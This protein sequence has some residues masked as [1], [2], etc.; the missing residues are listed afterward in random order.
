MIQVF[1]THR[2]LYKNAVLKAY[3]LANPT[4]QIHFYGYDDGDLGLE[5]QTNENGYICG[6]SGM[7]IL[8]SLGVDE[9][10]IIKVSL[11]GGTSWPI[12]WVLDNET[13]N[14]L[15]PRDIGTLGYYDADGVRQTWDPT[16]G[17]AELPN[18]GQDGSTTWDEKNMTIDGS[19]CQYAI[20]IWT[21]NIVI[22]TTYENNAVMLNCNSSRAGQQFVIY[23]KQA[24]KNRVVLGFVNGPQPI[25][26]PADM[27]AIVGIYSYTIDDEE[28]FYAEFVIVNTSTLTEAVVKSLIADE[29]GPS[30]TQTN[31]YSGTIAE[32]DQVIN[33]TNEPDTGIYFVTLEATV[34]GLKDVTINVPN[35][36]HLGTCQIV[37]DMDYADYHS[38]ANNSIKIAIGTDTP[39]EV[40]K[41]EDTNRYQIV[42]T[43]VTWN[44]GTIPYH[45]KIINV[46]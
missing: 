6:G 4:T 14:M 35:P 31:G 32:N 34:A 46:A 43:L 36:A 38:A 3:S 39:L 29:N 30:R 7:E 28:R 10:A 45:H 21:K 8:Q 1:D 42:V 40:H 41:A 9:A 27:A 33:C 24:T 5:V 44:D 23:N 20:D 12:E 18:Y 17:D 19:E 11:D 2:L 37:L 22:K 13:A 26:I 16:A 15:T 25:E